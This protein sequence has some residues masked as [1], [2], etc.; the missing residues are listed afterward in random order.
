VLYGSERRLAGRQTT[1]LRDCPPTIRVPSKGGARTLFRDA[2]FQAVA[3]RQAIRALNGYAPRA[4][5]HMPSE[6][7]ISSD[8]GSKL[9][10]MKLSASHRRAIKIG[11]AKAKARKAG[12]N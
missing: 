4:I 12:A 7:E 9:R 11:I 2:P 5:H 1:A 10:G 3:I 8:R 6:I